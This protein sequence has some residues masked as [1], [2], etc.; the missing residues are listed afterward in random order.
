[1]ILLLYLAFAWFAVGA[2]IG[3]CCASYTCPRC[4]S[5]T[6][7]QIQI[8]IAG[9]TNGTCLTCAG[10]N[11]TYIVANPVTAAGNC[12]WQASPATNCTVNNVL[13]TLSGI[14]LNVFLRDVSTTRIQFGTAAAGYNTCTWSSFGVTFGSS[15]G[16]CTASSATCTITAL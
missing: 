5:S 16:H 7:L 6:P 10:L 13:L 14:A 2:S 9:V 1:M 15:S 11:G 4:T 8:D 3:C 12:S